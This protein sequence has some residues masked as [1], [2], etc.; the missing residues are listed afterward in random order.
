MILQKSLPYDPFAPRPLPGIA[1]LD[2]ADWIRVDEAYG[3]QMAERE[4]LIRERRDVVIAL[5][6]SARMAAEELLDNVIVAVL[7]KP[8]FSLEAGV[9][10]RPDGGAVKIDRADP[11]AT[12]GRIVQEDFC[13]LEKRG[14]EHVLVGGILCFPSSWM[15][16]EKF[17]RP[18]VSIHIPVTP[19]D[20]NIA[21]RVQRLFDGVQPGR[22][23]WRF[24]ALWYADA[25]LH[26]PRR[27]NERRPE[28]GA[29][30]AEFLRSEMQ[31]VRRLPESGTVVFGIH[32]HVLARE[33]AEALRPGQRG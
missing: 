13:L 11:L 12:V 26:Q 16:E 10:M 21:K 20:E 29:Q 14:D 5:D 30:T 32:T 1:P 8:G 15:L 6:D 27:E 22:P 25:A 23:L 28:R 4:R 3:A 2:P 31:T 7:E 18:L 33:D 19:Y 9:V 17:L 24:N